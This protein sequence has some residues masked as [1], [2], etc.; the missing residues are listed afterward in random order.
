[1]IRELAR[2]SGQES[3]DVVKWSRA[4]MG[5]IIDTRSL[6]KTLDTQR[7]DCVLHLA[8]TPTSHSDYRTSRENFQ[9]ARATCD[10]ARLV[11]DCGGVFVGVGTGLELHEDLQDS[12]Y[13]E[14]KAF[15]LEFLNEMDPSGRWLWLRP[16]WI[17]SP[18]DL[19]PHVLREVQTS[20]SQ[21][22]EPTLQN[23]TAELDFVHVRDVATA[24]VTALSTG[25]TRIQDIGSGSL[26]S[27]MSLI[28]AS[29][30]YTSSQR[31]YEVD[32]TSPRGQ[33]Y[34]ADIARLRR[35]GWTPS[36]TEDFFRGSESR[37]S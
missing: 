14:S 7:P 29:T 15:V 26:Q 5:S 9:W 22:L 6:D 12:P 19:R 25:V 17:F 37:I 18:E 24:V 36:F 34:R 20:L 31:E 32:G 8:W 21:G 2:N 23:P 16:F 35:L 11:E 28:T 13:V 27:V 33:G 3:F 4:Q 1:M 10:L 30:G